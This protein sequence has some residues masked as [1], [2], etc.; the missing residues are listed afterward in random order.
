MPAFLIGAGPYHYWG[1][2]GWVG[3][4]GHWLPDVMDRKLGAPDA[5]GAYDAATQ[6]WTRTFG[7]GATKVVF[8]LKTNTGNV[9]WADT[10][11]SA[12]G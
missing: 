1:L 2:G 3:V 9:S 12:G 4:Q 10:T 5:D 6:V 11:L 8:D 7:N